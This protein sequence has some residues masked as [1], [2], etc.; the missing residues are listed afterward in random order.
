MKVMPSIDDS[1]L[2]KDRDSR[3][4]RQK[5]TNEREANVLFESSLFRMLY[6][7]SLSKTTLRKEK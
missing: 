2:K 3:D 5:W 4:L 7:I 1:L 6:Q